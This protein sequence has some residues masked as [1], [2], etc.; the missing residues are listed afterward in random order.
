MISRRRPILFSIAAVFLALAAAVVYAGRAGLLRAFDRFMMKE[1]SLTL[2]RYVL[3]YDAPVDPSL[4]RE[5]EAIDAR[6]REKLGMMPEHAAVGLLDLRRLRLAMVHPDR[7][8]YAASVAKIG[9]LLAYFQLKPEAA[10]QLDPQVRHELG[11]M[12]KASSNEFAAKFSREFGLKQIQ[13][14]LDSYHFYD[15]N[16][17]GGMWVGRHY[18][19]N[20]ERYG[21]PLADHSHAVTVRH[22]LRFYLM[23]EQGKLVSPEASRTMREI[24]DSPDIPHDQIKF[25]KALSERPDVRIL[26]KW[27]TWEEWLHDSAI[28]SGPSRHYILVGLTHHPR[29]DEYLEGLASEVD[30]LLAR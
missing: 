9:I 14:V 23:L 12:A 3:D 8:T 16:R 24:F 26:R 2:D 17:G 10:H 13:E 19:S 27:G 29:G 20:D 21:D 6:I 7:I 11:L 30:D 15:I 4:Q 25:V 18:G 1:P 28:V 5:I 22:V